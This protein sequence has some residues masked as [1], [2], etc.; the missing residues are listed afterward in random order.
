MP[1]MAADGDVQLGQYR[2]P[3]GLLGLSALARAG[4]ARS[5]SGWVGPGTM[6]NSLCRASPQAVPTAQARGR[7][8]IR[9]RPT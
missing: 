6:L 9:A 3:N 2:C 1:L 7:G 4:M 5:T 8:S